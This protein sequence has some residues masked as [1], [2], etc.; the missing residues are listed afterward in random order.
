M[1][2]M[3]HDF[4]Y[5]RVG[6]SFML[7]EIK[8]GLWMPRGMGALLKAKIPKNYYI[9]MLAYGDEVCYDELLNAKMVDATCDCDLSEIKDIVNSMPIL[10]DKLVF[11][12]RSE[13]L[14]QIKLEL[15]G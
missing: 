12:E 15:Y 9:K 2:A 4:R 10:K 8:N 5:C 14:Q 13:R 6:T 1:I 3:A 7:N 11:L